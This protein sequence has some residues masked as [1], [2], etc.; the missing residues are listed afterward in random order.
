MNTQQQQQ[1]RSIW[2][3]TKAAFQAITDT[4]TVTAIATSK[5][6]MTA[7]ELASTG[8][9]MAESNHRLVAFENE[10]K[11]KIAMQRLIELYGSDD[12]EPQP[13]AV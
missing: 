4:V 10:Q 11:E 5:V 12:N 13:A 3:N 6:A 9:C 1:P 8:L 7:D 2:S